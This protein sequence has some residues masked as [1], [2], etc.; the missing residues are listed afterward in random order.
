IF[1]AQLRPHAQRLYFAGEQTSSGFFGYMEGA[2]QSGARAARDI[3]GVAARSCPQPAG[4][5]FLR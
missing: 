1:P 2:L 4:V 5:R 3:I